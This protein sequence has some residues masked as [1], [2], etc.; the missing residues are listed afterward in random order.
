MD[1]ERFDRIARTLAGAA[2]RRAAIKTLFGGAAASLLATVTLDETGAKK[3]HK[4]RHGSHGSHG[5]H[6]S[7]HCVEAGKPCSSRTK[8]SCCKDLSCVHGRCACGSGQK[9]CSG[10]CIDTDACCTGKDCGRHGVCQNGACQCPPNKKRCKGACIATDACCADGDC[11]GDTPECRDNTCSC[12]QK[13]VCDANTQC[14]SGSCTCGSNPE[15]GSCQ[16]PTWEQDFSKHLDGWYDN[17]SGLKPPQHSIELNGDGTAQVLP[18]A[19]TAFSTLGGYGSV[20][21]TDGYAVS[22]DIYLDTAVSAAFTRF[23]YTSALN[24]QDCAH[25]QDFIFHA[26]VGADTGKF[27]VGTSYTADAGNHSPCY[28][29]LDP[30][31]ITDAGWHTFVHEFTESGG[32][33]V[34]TLKLLKG[35]TVIKSWT[36]PAT[37]PGDPAGNRYA[38]FPIN[39][40]P[41]GVKIDNSRRTTL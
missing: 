14:C 12:R 35:N 34:G 1:H 21:P 15:A 20:F 2:S 8:Q 16:Q 36:R 40:F 10:R 4:Q 30:V 22:L 26:G 37:Q 19:I 25:R 23:A 7:E 27:C 29:G 18:G 5:P 28:S 17:D 32:G 13:G 38:W 33:V 3:R 6:G 11:S 31:E 24:K 9:A 41:D 39:N